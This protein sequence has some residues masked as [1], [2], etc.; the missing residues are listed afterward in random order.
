MALQWCLLS[1]SGKMQCWG[2]GR[3]LARGRAL[4]RSWKSQLRRFRHTLEWVPN[5]TGIT[6]PLSVLKRLINLHDPMRIE[7]T[8]ENQQGSLIET[9]VHTGQRKP[10]AMQTVKVR[11]NI[12]LETQKAPLR[13]SQKFTQD[14]DN[15]KRLYYNRYLTESWRYLDSCININMTLLNLLL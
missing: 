8:R 12:F 2:V 11:A 5:N 14:G 13:D 10:L 1:H 6:F 9:E 3:A 7:A 15:F 4:D